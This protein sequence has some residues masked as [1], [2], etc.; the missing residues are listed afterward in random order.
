MK[1]KSTEQKN[2]EQNF[3]FFQL[4]NDERELAIYYLLESILKA[5]DSG[6]GLSSG[7]FFDEDV[8]IYLAH[9][10][11]AMSLPEY[12]D[13]ADPFISN[14][15]GEVSEWIRQT[16]DPMLR[17]FIYKVNADNLLV[18]N[19]LFAGKPGEINRMIYQ[20]A[21]KGVSRLAV[22]YYEHAARCHKGIYQKKTGV[23]QVLDKISGRY[24]LY[25]KILLRIKEDYF[26]FI[27]CFREQAFD[28][29]F[30]Q[31]N[32]YERLN[33]KD[34]L[35]DQFLGVYQSWL[36]SKVPG[37]RDQ[38]RALAME[39]KEIDPDFRFDLSKLS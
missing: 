8:N 18:K 27:N 9:L 3:L 26:Q 28:H 38:A 4:N 30:T 29:F 21:E 22:A 15:P 5:R 17:Y 23:G 16:D 19:T 33:R 31:M 2:P 7:G 1:N 6:P 25:Q 39:L 37:L 11:F 14:D 36:V 35:L 24:D 32:R 10:L 12:H 20:K 13:M 34:D